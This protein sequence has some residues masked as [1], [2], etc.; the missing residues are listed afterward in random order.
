MLTE[1]QDNMEAPANVTVYRIESKLLMALI[2]AMFAIICTTGG[3]IFTIMSDRISTL[4]TKADAE[5]DLRARI[6]VLDTEHATDL[7]LIQEN[8][9]GEA[10]IEGQFSK[11]F[12]DLADI[13]MHMKLKAAPDWGGNGKIQPRTFAEAPRQEVL[14]R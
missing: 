8:K 2:A 11:I 5:A 12:Q 14:M 13:R 10:R 6:A 9:D 3:I 7:A 4:E 1:G